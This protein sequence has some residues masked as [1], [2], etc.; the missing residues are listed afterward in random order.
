M[1]FLGALNVD[2]VSN[3]KGSAHPKDRAGQGNTEILAKDNQRLSL[4][5]TDVQFSSTAQRV[6]KVLSVELSASLQLGFAESTQGG[7]SIRAENT[8]F[9]YSQ[10]SLSGT[11]SSSLSVSFESTSLAF[12][13]TAIASSRQ[14][15]V[16][17][18]DEQEDRGELISG[19][20]KVAEVVFGFVA[21]RLEKEK[22]EGADQE[23]LSAL[24]EQAK[25]G[26]AKGIG[27]A[28][29][30]LEQLNE[31][32]SALEEQSAN[33]KETITDK[34]D[35]VIFGKASDD[36]LEQ[37]V[38]ALTEETLLE[39][40]VTDGAQA[41][42]IAAVPTQSA[43][44]PRTFE[45]LVSNFLTEKPSFA[46]YQGSFEASRRDSFSIDITTQDG[47]TISLSVLSGG[48]LSQTS[49]LV[50]NGQGRQLAATQE[51][52]RFSALSFEVNGDIDEA[53]QVAIE[54]LFEQVNQLA[55][56]FYSGDVGAAFEAALALDFDVSEISGFDLSLQTSQSVR[57]AEAYQQISPVGSERPSL[58]QKLGGYLQD[59]RAGLVDLSQYQSVPKLSDYLT[60]LLP[61]AISQAPV[62]N[63]A[64][65]DQVQK[66]LQPLASE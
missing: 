22:E 43:Q 65:E 64:P 50:A 30:V 52:E 6:Q 45:P 34:I 63:P 35:E 44:A 21:Q 66:L 29:R 33:L 59:V 37:E 41:G 58:V 55:N 26:V 11:A 36:T 56:Q 10:Q 27:D 53:E 51:F 32:N 5:N 20:D 1:P 46:A 48:S 24:A 54:A 7:Q 13:Q 25:A 57:V 61:A 17:Q 18:S 8:E 14:A 3:Y 23:R 31:M 9:V 39:Q 42:P 47:D 49:E 15:D 38:A 60:T 12:E 2:L 62:E 19:L 4:Q 40:G 16:D 28:G